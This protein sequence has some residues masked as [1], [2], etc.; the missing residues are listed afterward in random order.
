MADPLSITASVVTLVT[1]TIHSVK[2]L[3]GTVSRF[4][5]RNRTLQRLENELQGIID[6]LNSLKEV[7]DA[8]VSISKL[9]RGPID[10]CSEVC[11]EFEQ[12]METFSKK[13]KAGFL[14]WAKLEFM[15]GDINE[16]I[17][18]ISGYK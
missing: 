4:K 11:K 2:S 10:R 8:E 15:R 3:H 14:D 16:F 18:T 7:A 9:L 6:I 17:D 5:G 1:V 13:S 12:S